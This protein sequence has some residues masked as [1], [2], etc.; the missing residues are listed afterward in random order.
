M[1]AQQ[2]LAALAGITLLFSTASLAQNTALISANSAKVHPAIEDVSIRPF[3]IK[4]PKEAL[5][6][7]HR[8]LVLK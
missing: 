7:L 2:K 1:N 4:V 8:R 6:E 3:H 5:V